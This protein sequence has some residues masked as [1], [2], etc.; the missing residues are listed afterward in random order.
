MKFIVRTFVIALALTGAAATAL[1]PSASAEHTVITGR[2]SFMPIPVCPPDDPN[3][4]S[5]R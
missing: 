3:A 4:C 5:K 2:T 1:T